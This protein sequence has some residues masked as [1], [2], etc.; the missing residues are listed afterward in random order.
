MIKSSLFTT[1]AGLVLIFGAGASFGAIQFVEQDGVVVMEAEHYSAKVEGASHPFVLVPDDAPFT[2]GGTNSIFMNARGGRF[3][4]IQPDDGQN[5]GN[6]IS[7]VGT[8][9]YMEYTMQI[10]TVGEYQLYLRAIGWDGGS[11]SF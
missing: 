9:P 6:D 3:L 2:A 11:D 7:L 10:S 8:P 1:A 4:Q 5:K